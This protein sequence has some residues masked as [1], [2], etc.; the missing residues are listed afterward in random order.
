VR[1]NELGF[2]RIAASWYSLWVPVTEYGYSRPVT[3]S[4]GILLKLVLLVYAVFQNTPCV[5]ATDPE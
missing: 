5:Q 3:G 4:T 1:L 2:S